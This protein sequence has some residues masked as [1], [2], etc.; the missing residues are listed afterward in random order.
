MKG[1]IFGGSIMG[2]IERFL[3]H[4]VSRNNW[5]PQQSEPEL[6]GEISTNFQQES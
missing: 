5:H 2:P 4:Q 3:S 6:P 1:E